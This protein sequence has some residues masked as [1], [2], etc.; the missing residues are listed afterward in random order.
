MAN[1][2]NK[3]KTKNP[4]SFPAWPI[5]W[6]EWD[7]TFDNFKKD[8]EKTF[9]SFPSVSTTSLPKMH[10]S[11]DIIDEGKTLKITADVPGVKKNEIDLNVTENSIEIKAGHKEDT[12]E[13]KKNYLKKER[14]EVSYYRTL[15][16]PDKVIPG[17]TKA[18]LTDG[19]LSIT[20]PKVT[21]TSKSSK[22]TITVQ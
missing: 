1:I 13:K 10:T 16:L 8:M 2:K 11:C 22:K 19:V 6:P 15:S 20:L 7:R 5:N 12:E 14:S 18:N 21:P 3:S 4:L 17:R 9:A